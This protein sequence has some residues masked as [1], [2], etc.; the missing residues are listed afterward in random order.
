[1]IANDYIP[2]DL[3]II[4][5]LQNP[6]YDTPELPEIRRSPDREALQW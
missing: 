4:L 3:I 5:E 6:Y 1:M 2:T